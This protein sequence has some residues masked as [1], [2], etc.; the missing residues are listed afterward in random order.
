MK[1]TNQKRK[2]RY[3]SGMALLITLL[4]LSMMSVIAMG[5]IGITMSQSKISLNNTYS[6][7]ALYLA[8][9]GINRAQSLL[10]KDKT[11][12]PSYPLL[13]YVDVDGETGSY[14]IMVK[15]LSINPKD[16][17]QVWEVTS[18]GS[19]GNAK[20]TITAVI[21]TEPLSQYVY[22]THDSLW[23]WGQSETPDSYFGPLHTNAYFNFYGKPKFDGPLTSS[24]HNDDY[25][26]SSK[27]IYTQGST[28]TDDPSLFYRYVFDYDQ[29]KPMPAKGSNNFYFTGGQPYKA[30]PS[31]TT[32]QEENATYV[33]EGNVLLEFL[34]SGEMEVTSDEGTVLYSCNNTTLYATGNIQAKGKVKGNVTVV[35]NSDIYINDNIVYVDKTL[36][37]LA[38]IANGYVVLNT[39]YNDVR[40][41]EINAM[42]FSL[43]RSFYVRN[44]F[45]GSP[46]GTLYLYGGI[47]QKSA[48]G[49]GKYHSSTGKLQSGYARNFVFDSRF[50]NQ[51]AL[52]TPTTGKITLKAWQD[53]AAFD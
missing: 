6:V 38:L 52:N 23:L 44:F 13:K 41:I 51:P 9:S 18:T 28:V 45:L 16:T 20:R 40:D 15:K 39:D 11:W 22:Y 24:N 34:E 7:K 2:N 31:S 27:R 17:Y 25:F 14:S 26:D 48:G 19:L 4:C 33:V 29:D 43:N 49:I 12:L 10:E 42:I 5:L 3:A 36:D 8:R 46:R 35:S 32:A 37:S 30:L 1:N 21:S 50:L 47:I 53:S